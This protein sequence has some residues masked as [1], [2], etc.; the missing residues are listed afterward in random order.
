M[1]KNV[2]TLDAML[3][4]SSGLF[5]LAWSISRMTRFPYRGTY[6]MVGMM[7]AMMVAQGVTR[8]CTILDLLGLST[9]EGEN[10][11]IKKKSPND[12]L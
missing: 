9:V 11:L 1:K 8:Y 4:I 7:S 10:S 2:G 3:R 6:I 5:S 12:L